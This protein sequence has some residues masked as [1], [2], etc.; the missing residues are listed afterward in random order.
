M[1]FQ[2]ST[3]NVVFREF[4]RM[5]TT[6][7]PFHGDDPVQVS[8]VI[9][10]LTEAHEKISDLPLTEET[11]QMV[12]LLPNWLEKYAAYPLQDA[13]IP[14]ADLVWQQKYLG[15]LGDKLW[16]EH[17]DHRELH[18]ADHAFKHGPLEQAA[19]EVTGDADS[20]H[21]LDKAAK[22]KSERAESKRSEA[23]G[24]AAMQH[25]VPLGKIAKGTRVFKSE[26]KWR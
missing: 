13:L 23:I 11:Q 22:A 26:R 19:A 25:A 20:A 9:S 17:V 3:S 12:A 8:Q 15:S 5:L 7:Y 24:K 6:R 2:M 14:K 21:R 16:H 10:F 18:Y 4:H 1:E